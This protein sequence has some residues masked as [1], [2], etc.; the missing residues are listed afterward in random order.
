[1]KEWKKLSKPIAIKE[2]SMARKFTN[3]F[4]LEHSSEAPELSI[5]SEAEYRLFTELKRALNDTEIND[6]EK[7]LAFSMAK[8]RSSSRMAKFMCTGTRQFVRNT[9]SKNLF[10]TPTQYSKR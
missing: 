4:L 10:V 2:Y 5:R 6:I 8:Q 7:K 1:M 3:M 9:A